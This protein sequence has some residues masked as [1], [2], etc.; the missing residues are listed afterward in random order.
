MDDPD[1]SQEISPGGCLPLDSGILPEVELPPS[2]IGSHGG[3]L[4]A[5]PDNQLA[6]SQFRVDGDT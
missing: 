6:A 3:A 5:M 2:S 1:V 4:H